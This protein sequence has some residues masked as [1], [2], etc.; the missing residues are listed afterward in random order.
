MNLTHLFFSIFFT[1]LLF[2]TFVFA[3][4]TQ[5]LNHSD[6]T[7]PVPY[8]LSFKDI[9]G[10]LVKVHKAGYDMYVQELADITANIQIEKHRVIQ[11]KHINF[12]FEKNIQTTD[13]LLDVTRINDIS[14]SDIDAIDNNLN[15]K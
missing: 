6:I 3:I 13:I 4:P 12:L 9:F 11:S 2:P 15:I 10:P 14:N 7:V 5:I 1:V 8:A